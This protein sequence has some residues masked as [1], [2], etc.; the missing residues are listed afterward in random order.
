[1]MRRAGIVTV[2]TAEVMYQ[3][4]V[5]GLSQQVGVGSAFI[6]EAGRFL[7][8][9]G[10]SQDE[11]FAVCKYRVPPVVVVPTVQQSVVVPDTI[12]FGF[13]IKVLLNTKPS[14][15]F[16]ASLDMPNKE[17]LIELA[18][19]AKMKKAI[20]EPLSI[21]LLGAPNPDKK[22]HFKHGQKHVNS[23]TNTI[24]RDPMQELNVFFGKTSQLSW[25]HSKYF[26]ADSG[27]ILGGIN[28]D[29][30]HYQAG[31]ADIAL[32]FDSP[33]LALFTKHH[34]Y[35]QCEQIAARSNDWSPTSRNWA[36][37]VIK[38]FDE[39]SLGPVVGEYHSQCLVAIDSN[40]AK[41]GEGQ[42]ASKIIPWLIDKAESEIC[43]SQQDIGFSLLR[44]Y[45]GSKAG[46]L[47]PL[48]SLANSLGKLFVREIMESLNKAFIRGVKV[49]I[50]LS[51]D[52]AKVNG[53][54]YYYLGHKETE[55]YLHVNIDKKHHHLLEVIP[56]PKGN[57]MK[58][59]VVDK[60]I[61]LVGSKNMYRT[62]LDDTVV[63]IED[64]GVSDTI[65]KVIEA[66]TQN[67]ASKP[68]FEEVI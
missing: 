36:S 45:L 46:I 44:P 8:K 64:E 51:A 1:M 27:L 10:E 19:L 2:Q 16:I 42:A 56:A 63:I 39:L 11:T 48:E 60:R 59:M 41:K 7:A 5:R 43:I 37:H 62:N 23:I 33:E 28:F 53:L 25:N 20:S 29:P 38:D 34:M 14:D 30:S 66:A 47:R 68:R 12:D 15:L 55:R 65:L 67:D 58:A 6:E 22:D 40:V 31:V 9:K 49:K 52:G 32:M 18:N 3:R 24:E 50:V 35:M 13:A 21:T 4:S 54:P 61:S 17:V 26:I 57:H